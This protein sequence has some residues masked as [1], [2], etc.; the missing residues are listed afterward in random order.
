MIELESVYL[1]GHGVVLEPMR[2]EH[3]DEIADAA[4]EGE[5]WRL[6]FTYVP[7]PEEAMAYVDRYHDIVADVDL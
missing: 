7:A 5:Q 2:R 3:A 1:A 6:F 4:G